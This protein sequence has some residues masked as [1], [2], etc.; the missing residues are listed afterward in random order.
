MFPK[1]LQQLTKTEAGSR[2]TL[3]LL[4]DHFTG[5]LWNLPLYCCNWLAGSV[6]ERYS[7][8]C[9]PI[10]ISFAK[11]LAYNTPK[12]LEGWMEVAAEVE[13]NRRYILL[14]CYIWYNYMA[15]AIILYVCSVSMWLYGNRV[16]VYRLSLYS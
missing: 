4:I 1:F 5:I 8:I 2:F 7:V 9:Y 10:M 3:D 11:L 6:K 16:T 12:W 14:A 13:N 15:I